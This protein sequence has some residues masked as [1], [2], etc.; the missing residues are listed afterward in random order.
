MQVGGT[1]HRADLPVAEGAG[2]RHRCELLAAGL[3]I[4][5]R[6][7]VETFAAAEAGSV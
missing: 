1:T 6:L 4:A 3:D 7:A 2:H 5:I